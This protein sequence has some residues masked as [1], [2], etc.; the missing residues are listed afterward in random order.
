MGAVT[1]LRL[2]KHVCEVLGVQRNK[3]T[4]WVDSCNVGYWIHGRSRNFKPFVAHRVG[5]IHEES[6]PDQWRY[7]PGKLILLTKVR[8]DKPLRID[9]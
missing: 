5:A 4:C 8:E 1:G 9:Q 2:T 6:N 7:V 3:A